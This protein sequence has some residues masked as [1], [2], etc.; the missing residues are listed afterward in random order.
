MKHIPIEADIL[1]ELR[2]RAVDS[3][4]SI[5]DTIRRELR[6]ETLEVDDE[7]YDYLLIAMLEHGES[8]AK[9]MRRE[10]GEG[11]RPP[12]E[13]NVVEF[14]IPPGTGRH[15]W[16][17]RED[18]VTARV[19]DILR[20]INDDDVPHRLHTPGTP[21]PHPATDIEPGQSVDQVLLTP[22]EPGTTPL[23]DHGFGSAAVFWLR[24]L[25]VG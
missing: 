13:P 18:I 23:F 2:A 10:L 19:G 5:S 12:R 11:R 4:K 20:L 3:D 8:F 1:G 15:P 16:N 22:F 7:V 9:M 14:H 6:L 25:P 24:V 17:V 21:F